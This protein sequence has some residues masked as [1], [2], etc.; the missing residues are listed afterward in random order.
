MLSRRRL[1][2]QATAAG[3]LLLVTSRT[4]ASDITQDFP[5]DLTAAIKKYTQGAAWKEH[6]VVF[7]IAELIDNGNTVP[8]SVVVDSPMRPDAYV[9]SIAVFNEKNPNRD[10]AMFSLTPYGG[11]AE[12]ATRIRLATSQRLIAIAQMSDGTYC[13]KTVEVIV[14]LASCIEVD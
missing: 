7:E 12:V 1:M 9:K 10:V 8:I 3:A 13:S 14:T 4:M 11:K 2:Q 6:K 5:D